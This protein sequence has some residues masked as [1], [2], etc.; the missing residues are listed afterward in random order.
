M[1]NKLSSKDMKLIQR[2][3]DFELSESELEIFDQK[4]KTDPVF[5]KHVKMFQS[6]DILT[7]SLKMET[8]LDIQKKKVTASGSKLSKG[9]ILLIFAIVIG[10]LAFHWFKPFGSGAK[11]EKVFAEVSQYVDKISQSAMRGEDS[12]KIISPNHTHFHIDQINKTKDDIKGL[13][14][15]L[16]KTPDTNTQE[17]ILWTMVKTNLKNGDIEAAKEVLDNIS[18]NQD[19]NSFKK[20]KGILSNL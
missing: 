17:I 6:A 15:L 11:E 4:F 20:A 12:L 18:K 3:I 7:N 8:E 16:S 2:F 13:E 9:I 14:N 19:F 5:K 10:L 1:R